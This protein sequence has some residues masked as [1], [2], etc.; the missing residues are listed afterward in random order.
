MKLWVI[1][2]LFF[3]ILISN[4][5]AECEDRILEYH[6]C[7][8]K[9]CGTGYAKEEGC[10]DPCKEI[11]ENNECAVDE[12]DVCLKNACQVT[13]TSD[14]D[15]VSADGVSNITF[16]LALSGD[17]ETFGFDIKPNEGETLKGKTKKI[18]DKKIIFTPNEANKDKDYLVPQAAYA[19]GWCT[20]KQASCETEEPQKEEAKKDFTIEQPPIFFVHGI[21]SD[22]DVWEKFEQRAKKNGWQYEDITY[23]TQDN[24]KNAGQLSYET[25]D[26]I[27]KISTGGYYNR[28]RISATKV[29]IVSHS[30][31]GVVTRYYIGSGMYNGNIRKFIMMGT[32]NHG[33]YDPKILSYPTWGGYEKALEQ[34]TPGSDFLKSLN[35]KPQKPE[36]KYYTIA[37]TG[38]ST[39]IGF[40]K[41]STWKGDGVVL[42]DSVRLPNVPLYCTYDT[43]AA[44]IYWINGGIVKKKGFDTSKGVVITTSEAAYE[45]AKSL[46]LTGS[47]TNVANCDEE[48]MPDPSAPL[49][50]RMEKQQIARLKSPATLHAYDEKDNHIGLNKN[51]KVENTIGE[52]AYYISNSSGI[53]GQVIN[54]IGDRK[55]KFVVKGYGAGNIGLEFTSITEYGN[56]TEKSFENVSI[57]ARTQYVFDASSE[58]P[59]LVKGELEV[60]KAGYSWYMPLIAIFAIVFGVVLLVKKRKKK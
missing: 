44:G 11:L 2:V 20:P 4:G 59:E 22:S 32:P 37:G 36:I 10:S 41:L 53:E 3:I 34:L 51:G 60:E 31:G 30:M 16:T 14:F 33:A 17:Y 56:V 9:N 38:W 25:K 5:Y 28:K 57:D 7:N 42:V 29:D 6:E 49:K 8:I 1:S 26:F 12:E 27:K 47:A 21:W 48:Y 13:V 43:H 39:H 15:G 19:A 55:I 24:V 58:K 35:N 18:S 40:E 45:I 23:P 46:L 52:D 54:V 50:K